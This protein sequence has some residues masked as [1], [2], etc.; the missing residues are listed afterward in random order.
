MAEPAPPAPPT[1]QELLQELNGYMENTLLI[2][3]QAVRD[4]LN[5]QGLTSVGDFRG[6]KEE[7]IAEICANARKPG[8]TIPNPAYDAANPV[9]GIPA[10][11]MNPGVLVGHVL[12][13]RLKMFGYF[14][15]YLTKVG[16]TFSPEA[17]TLDTVQN[18]Y[19]LKEADD[20]YDNDIELPEKLSNVEK[21]RVVLE[22]L[23]DYLERKRGVTMIPL[24]AY[25]RSMPTPPPINLDPGLG[26]PTYLRELI[27]RAPL[28]GATA[29]ADK[30]AVWDVIRHITH[31]GPGWGWVQA[32]SRSRDGRG[33][34]IA[35]KSHYFGD[36]FQSRLRAKADQVLESTYYDGTKR[37][38]TYKRYIE[39]LQRAFTDLESTG[40]VVSNERKVRVLLLGV[41]DSRLESA[42]NTILATPAL[43]ANFEVASNYLAEVLDSK[44][45][46][47]ATTR[48]ARISSIQSNK[49]GGNGNKRNNG[50][51]TPTKGFDPNKYY[52]F[53]KWIKLSKEQQQMVREARD[54]ANSSTKKRS[55]AA[56]H[57]NNKNKRKGHDSSGTSTTY[58]NSETT[59]D[60]NDQNEKELGV[61]AIMSQRKKG[62]RDI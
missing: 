15:Q 49:N 12:E 4:A 34:Y 58:D 40:K 24:A 59:G 54:V 27:R 25:T 33:A 9:A 36:A 39:S 3:Q 44:V 62:K 45:S 20:E 51:Q 43:R 57:I 21:F 41:A 17:A 7:D 19:R 13:K 28:T 52:P 23:D 61:G 56:I 14:V 11:V 26:S 42:K 22:D 16:R 48:K 1:A 37:N 38:Y 32:F 2:G 60:S 47:S 18:L 29:V 35:L 8:G 55:A 10:M 46:Y 31:N 30:E 6:L 50:H 53:R 5:S